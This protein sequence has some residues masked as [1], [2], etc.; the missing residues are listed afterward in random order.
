MSKFTESDLLELFGVFD[1]DYI[2]KNIAG[3]PQRFVRKWL[4]R[5]NAAYEAGIFP[6]DR[7]TENQ[8]L[9]ILTFTGKLI[10][11]KFNSQIGISLDRIGQLNALGSQAAS[12]KFID[13]QK[14]MQGKG[15]RVLEA[16]VATSS[17]LD[18]RAGALET[19]RQDEERLRLQK[20]L[21]RLKQEKAYLSRE[22]TRIENEL[23]TV[24]LECERVERLLQ[25]NEQSRK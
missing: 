4:T 21:E 16:L 8:H 11:H 14:Q 17:W 13:M 18:S 23:C 12:G 7:T 3:S 9:T 19:R 20:T 2:A 5:I 22:S 1:A 25:E 15:I 6:L 24:T 10:R